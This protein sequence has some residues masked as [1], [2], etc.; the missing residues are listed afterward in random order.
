M[1]TVDRVSEARRRLAH[2]ETAED[3]T[4]LID[5]IER[6]R[7][8]CRIID[9]APA[10]INEIT[11]VKVEARAKRA[12]LIDAGQANGIFREPGRPIKVAQRQPL[13]VRKETVAEDRVLRDEL[14]EMRR[15]IAAATAEITDRDLLELARRR[16]AQRTDRE[17]RVIQPAIEDHVAEMWTLLAG[18]MQDRMA[19]IDDASI[20]II[21]T[22]PPYPTE[23]LPLWSDLAEHAARVLIPGGIVVAMSGKIM[24]PDVIRR[25][26]EHL[27]YGWV[28]CQPLPGDSSRILARHVGQEWKPWLAYSNGP[29][30]SGR[31][32]WHGDV[33]HG[34]PKMKDRYHWQ[35]SEQPAGELIVRLSPINGVVLDPFCG[36]GTYGRAALAAGRR[37]IGI[38]ADASRLAAAADRLAAA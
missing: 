12:D 37:F 31:V 23:F 20:D 5:D 15:Q 33:L 17:A 3:A 36:V 28:Y 27:H 13:P 19:D 21:V 9:T 30:P 11:L 25:L 32:D 34:V 14:D 10:E 7:A 6:V 8:V 29:W 26:G 16:R 2:L 1:S 22:D 35:Q 38:D 4:D 18:R 24:L